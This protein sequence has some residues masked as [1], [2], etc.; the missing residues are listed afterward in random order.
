MPTVMAIIVPAALLL[1]TGEAQAIIVEAM[2]AVIMAAA[3]V[4]A[5]VPAVT[6]IN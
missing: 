6:V 2:A 1:P 5:I 3:T 4:V